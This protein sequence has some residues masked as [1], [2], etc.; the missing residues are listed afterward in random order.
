M[1]KTS[2]MFNDPRKQNTFRILVFAF[3]ICSNSISHFNSLKWI[4]K[5]L[6]L[7]DSGYLYLVLFIVHVSINWP[8]VRSPN[9]T[10]NRAIQKGLHL[11]IT[12]SIN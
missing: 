8:A 12:L 7:T 6:A 10:Q 9:C 4:L 2:W 11:K 1:G 5:R 3:A